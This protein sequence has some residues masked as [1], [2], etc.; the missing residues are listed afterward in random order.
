M[1]SYVL[2]G[3]CPTCGHP[4]RDWIHP[5]SADEPVLQGKQKQIFDAV[6]KAGKNGI[7]SE[8]LFHLLYGADPNG[9]PDFK[10]LAVIVRHLNMKLKKRGIK[11]WA[12]RGSRIYRLVE[13]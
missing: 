13:A 9:G 4:V 12:G 2:A 5:P 1:G 6:E 11:V 8:R 3:N 10:C 7:H